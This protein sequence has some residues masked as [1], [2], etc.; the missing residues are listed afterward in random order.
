MGF[1]LGDETA[2]VPIAETRDAD[3]ATRPETSPAES[4][5]SRVETG[6]G[7]PSV[8]ASTLA[9]AT[10]TVDPG[11]P[12]E[13][14]AP[15]EVVR[16]FGDYEL[17][18]EVARG[19]MGVVFKARQVSLNRTVALKMILA[20]ALA[21]ADEV[22]RFHREAEAAANLDHPGIVPIYEIGEHQG[23]HYFSMGYV[24][25]PS[26]A[27]KLA[28]GPLPGL[29]AA[30]LLVSV[31]EAVQ[32][33][34]EEG[35]L[36]RDLK[37]ANVLLDAQGRP[38]VTDFGLAKP[39]RG[40]SD[41][42]ATGQVVGTP[43]YMPPE[44][45]RGQGDLGPEADVYSLGAI[46]YVALTGRPPFQAATTMET[47]LQ[48]LEQEPVAP[49]ALNPAVG[50]DLETI[51]LKALEKEPARRYESAR[52]FADDLR[53]SM[54]GEPIR[55]RRAPAWERALKWA[56]RRPA[57][58][59]LM[60]VGA[61]AAL[62]AVGLAVAGRY[63]GLL[64]RALR[65]EASLRVQAEQRELD[66][67]RYWYAADVNLARRYWQDAR[68]DRTVML[69][70]RQ[71]PGPN[72]RDLRGF[73]WSY[74]WRLCHQETHRS[75]PLEGHPAG[76]VAGGEQILA[77][78]VVDPRGPTP[79][80]EGRVV[81]LDGR[82]GAVRRVLRSSASLTQVVFAQ[83]GATWAG[84]DGADVVLGNVGS[85]SVR[86]VRTTAKVERM[87][88]LSPSGRWLFTSSEQAAP[89][90]Q[91]VD[92]RSGEI[93]ST[94]PDDIYA[95]GAAFAD[96]R[97]LAIGGVPQERDGEVR[98]ITSG[99]VVL[100][101][102]DVASS[103]KRSDLPTRLDWMGPLAFAPDGSTLVAGGSHSD[104]GLIEVWD[105]TRVILKRELAGHAGGVSCLA[106]SPDGAT[107]ASG[108]SDRLVTL[109]Q[110]A[111]DRT[112]TSWPGRVKATYRGHASPPVALAFASDGRTL[113]S[114]D[115]TGT[116]LFWDAKSDPERQRLGEHAYRIGTV[117]Y[118]PDG[119]RL[120]AVDYTHIS[121]Y[122]AATGRRIARFPAGHWVFAAAL[123][124]DGQ[125]LA[126]GGET[127]TG[128]GAPGLIRL[129]D[130]AGGRAI[131]DLQPGDDT[132]LVNA[133]AF[134]PDGRTLAATVDGR[135][136]DDEATA[137][138]RPA[139]RGSSVQLWDVPAR[140]IRVEL[141]GA[142]VTV[143]FSPDGR[144]LATSSPQSSVRI[145]DASDGTALA[146]LDAE[147]PAIF[148]PDGRSLVTRSPSADGVV[149]WDLASRHAVRTIPSVA[150]PL[151]IFPDGRT[152]VMS[153]GD[154]LV[155][156]QLAT[157]QELL[158]LTGLTYGAACAAIS[159][160]GSALA[161]GGGYRDENEGVVIWR[162]T[163]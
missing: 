80:T 44:Q 41:L 53:R 118:T 115:D 151:T 76:L 8:P 112:W 133:L 74:L 120:V 40:G 107:F 59:G 14:A 47:V 75:R 144:L 94:L 30:E 57:G 162:A 103:S 83:G 31:A 134:S 6:A 97:T 42:T 127:G 70:D 64:Q 52:G 136:F 149:V 119:R 32:F 63:N 56:H 62:C 155:L 37:P 65:S 109:R 51:C 60:A 152:L 160:D 5:A 11:R 38:R 129:F 28:A 81:G 157:G 106:V 73:E 18:E 50:R 3:R 1:A 154:D 34:H 122:D 43:S 148:A 141:P 159:P 93:R 16:Y 150:L 77:A 105:T 92:T 39:L 67:A 7:T 147:G 117:I 123:S 126:V 104:E 102:W 13:R 46:L 95:G 116:V 36:H 27:Q 85:G 48:V 90:G 69:L 142:A 82:T 153:E 121:V 132:Q 130:V 58:A 61:V 20:G 9:G 158:T 138:T 135:R 24:E 114:T 125:T 124:P 89:G 2:C 54:R 26:L 99:A 163:R 91:I 66:T 88:A 71:R 96:D 110:L 25:G 68:L 10:E 137:G 146:T 86:V 49:R 22:R 111:D 128:G 101:I 98:V 29:S 19:G 35:V 12:T 131:A 15:P 161:T 33:A 55:A 143:A 72:G 108:A 79:T 84:L 139:A 78:Q 45:A 100:R 145:R 140:R 4:E 156:Y 17:L 87:M 23:Q 21:S 113:C